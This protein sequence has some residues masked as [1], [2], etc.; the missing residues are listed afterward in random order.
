MA[1]GAHI[2]KNYG[3]TN[4]A[5]LSVTPEITRK[6]EQKNN[7]DDETYGTRINRRKKTNAKRKLLLKLSGGEQE[8]SGG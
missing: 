7:V 6:E 1:R 4:L 8:G 3:E 5:G 2:G